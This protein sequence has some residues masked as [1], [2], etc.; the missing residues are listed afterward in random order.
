MKYFS[1]IVGLSMMS[2]FASGATVSALSYQTNS[3]L[4][5]TYQNDAGYWFGCGPVQCINSGDGTE[6]K[7]KT[8]LAQSWHGSFHFIGSYGRCKVYSGN[9]SLTAG[10]NSPNR[11]MS[12]AE[13]K[14]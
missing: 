6:A 2:L 12:I 9:G 3:P 14:C 1:R 8:Y 11:L 10:D 7:A 5:F 13:G 4:M